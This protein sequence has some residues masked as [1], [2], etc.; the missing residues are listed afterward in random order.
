MEAILHDIGFVPVTLTVG[1]AY[2]GYF[3]AS[4]MALVS[5]AVAPNEQ[6]TVDF[7]AYTVFVTS[8]LHFILTATGYA[9]IKDYEHAPVDPVWLFLFADYIQAGALGATFGCYLLDNTNRT[10]PIVGNVV[11]MLTQLICFWKTYSLVTDVWT[12]RRD[13]R[14]GEKLKL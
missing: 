9:F 8:D 1:A 7:A 2:V 14:T 13:A 5:M 11:T 12:G 10:A 3:V 6:W 4:T